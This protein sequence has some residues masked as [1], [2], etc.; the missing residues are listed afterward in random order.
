M[1]Y[2]DIFVH[3]LFSSFLFY[4]STNL[5][6]IE[7]RH[8]RVSLQLHSKLLFYSIAVAGL[9]HRFQ[10]EVFFT[11]GNF[12]PP[13]RF[14]GKIRNVFVSP[15]CPISKE[16]VPPKNHMHTRHSIHTV[17]PHP[18]SRNKT[19]LHSIPNQQK[20][21]PIV[22]GVGR[23]G[24]P[25]GGPLSL[26]STL[27]DPGAGWKGGPPGPDNQGQFT[28]SG[29]NSFGAPVAVFPNAGQGSP[30][31]SSGQPVQYQG[32]PPGS[33]TPQYTASPAPSGSSTPG[34]GPPAN[35]SGAGF[36]PPPSGPY[37]GPGPGGPFGSPSGGPP[38]NRPNSS[39]PAFGGPHFQSQ[40]GPGGFGGPQFNM[41][42]GSPFGHG[43][44]HPMGPLVPA[45]H[46]MGSQP[47]DRMEQ[48]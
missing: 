3:I 10:N 46:L 23:R 25:P 30:A 32:P 38:F 33:N 26:P 20:K 17:A 36:P 29:P 14:Y 1:S 21:I 31:S 48:G 8:L 41:P 47:V 22:S 7:I 4:L 45:G 28:P 44:G 19:L 6:G 35:V 18:H 13:H 15:F 39:G 24:V 12:S 9:T 2:I 27:E 34:P 40:G 11:F 37:N 42:P 43:P 16:N 5:C